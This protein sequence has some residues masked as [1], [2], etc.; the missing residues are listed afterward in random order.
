MT[1]IQCRNKVVSLFEKYIEFES[2]SKIQEKLGHGT[3]PIMLHKVLRELTAEN[4]ILI[5]DGIFTWIDISNNP[6]MQELVKNS[7]P[8][9]AGENDTIQ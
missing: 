9:S 4:K 1:Y 5:N 3:D 7:I 2:I 8:L 6:K